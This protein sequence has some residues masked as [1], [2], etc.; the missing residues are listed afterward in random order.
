MLKFNFTVINS[1]D[2]SWGSPTA[3]GANFSGMI[4]MLQRGEADLSIAA[5]TLR[6]SRMEVI[7]L[8]ATVFTGS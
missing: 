4:G 3:D 8:S 5:F 2:G 1:V 7:D 6:S